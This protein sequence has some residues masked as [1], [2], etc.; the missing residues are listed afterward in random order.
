[1]KTLRY[2]T[3][4]LLHACSSA[5]NGV[6]DVATSVLDTSSPAPSGTSF[7][8]EVDPVE[9]SSSL[10]DL[11]FGPFFTSGIYNLALPTP[12]ELNGT[13]LANAPAPWLS[14]P[15]LP[16]TEASPEASLI[17]THRTN[18]RETF[19]ATDS[20]GAFQVLLEP[21]AAYDVLVI[22]D[23]PSVPPLSTVFV[24]LG[25]EEVFYG[26]DSATPIWGHIT[27]T[28]GAP[29]P[30]ARVTAS[31]LTGSIA[32]SVRT[33][34]EGAFLLQVQPGE[35]QVDVDDAYAG[36]APRVPLER[37][38]V[39]AL[40]RR[41]DGTLPPSGNGTLRLRMVQPNG[42]ALS[43]VA[44]DVTSVELDAYPKTARL[45][46]T[47][48]SDST[49]TIQVALPT[50]TYRLVAS[51]G[52]DLPFSSEVMTDVLVG[53]TTNDLGAW[54]LRRLST[55]ASSVLDSAGTTV[56]GTNLICQEREGAQRFWATISDG[57]GI[58]SITL[59]H[60]GAD[61][62][63]VP[64]GDRPDLASRRFFIEGA[65]LP[66]SLPL[67]VG[68]PFSGVLTREDDEAPVANATVRL[69]DNQQRI[70][71]T[72]LSNAD[73]AYTLRVDFDALTDQRVV[74]DTTSSKE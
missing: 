3:I 51:P 17:F 66:V 13:I 49:G 52:A 59:P 15:T 8:L 1:M 26:L 10:I 74:P 2:A 41:I 29:V 73:G 54:T 39:D 5:E 70:W 35:W 71:G 53:T 69:R 36:T 30:D 46:R 63:L 60:S 21:S 23:D 34:S 7:T 61:C 67:T 9:S 38:T 37:V 4:V 24:A 65:S 28:A 47:L 31:S 14:F 40:G 55:A 58:L 48:I 56:P 25:D 32:A 20:A 12:Y 42:A 19:T 22:P 6:S 44:L 57:L 45:S 33:D 64:P 68:E 27:D 18:G 43:G 50:G 16:S 62:L 11:A 72:T